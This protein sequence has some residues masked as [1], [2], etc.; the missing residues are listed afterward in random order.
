[1][2]GSSAPRSHAVCMSFPA[3]TGLIA[4]ASPTS[5]V[6]DFDQTSGRS[7]WYSPPS[8]S[9]SSRIAARIRPS[10]NAH[11]HDSSAA[12]ARTAP[13]ISPRDPPSHRQP[14]PAA[15]SSATAS[16]ADGTAEAHPPPGPNPASPGSDVPV[17][18]AP[19]GLSDGTPRSGVALPG[20][21]EAGPS[22][23]RLGPEVA[24][25]GRPGPGTGSSPA[26]L[27]PP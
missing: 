10:L 3:D 15:P 2:P 7:P 14:A 13:T 11:A 12:A 17:C 4:S 5:V 9:S 21:D 16:A 1:M 8:P 18:P 26:P 25:P 22:A 20:P 27:P 24:S 23:D 6:S 19:G